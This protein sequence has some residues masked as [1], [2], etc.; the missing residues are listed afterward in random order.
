M[1]VV[2]ITYTPSNTSA[3][4]AVLWEDDKACSTTGAPYGVSGSPAL[5]AVASQYVSA[6]QPTVIVI[7]GNVN[8]VPP[9][10]TLKPVV[11]E[12][13]N[14]TYTKYVNPRNTSLPCFTTSN[15]PCTTASGGQVQ[16]D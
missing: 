10:L 4:Y 3:P 15:A 2:N 13:I 7:I 11:G 6:A 8:Y 14:F 16:D 9:A 12:A 1:T 5:Q